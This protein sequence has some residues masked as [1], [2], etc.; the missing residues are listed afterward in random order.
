MYA[1]GKMRLV[2]TI[3]GIR[4]GGRK[5]SDGWHEFNYDML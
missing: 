1:N 5:K 2:E 3:L 4:K